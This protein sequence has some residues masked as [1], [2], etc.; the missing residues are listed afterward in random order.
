LVVWNYNFEVTAKVRLPEPL[1]T[2]GILSGQRDIIVGTSTELMKIPGIIFS[3]EVDQVNEVWDNFDMKPEAGVRPPG[4]LRDYLLTK[5]MKGRTMLLRFDKAAKIRQFIQTQNLERSYL[6]LDAV[7]NL[8]QLGGAPELDEKKARGIEEM[9]KLMEQPRP[10]E[11]KAANA[12]PIEPSQG[13]DHNPPGATESN[14][15]KRGLGLPRRGNETN[16]ETGKAVRQF[17]NQLQQ[18]ILRLRGDCRCRY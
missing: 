8:D 4:Q 3:G 7:Q 1:F 16:R 14:Q 9:R 17:G 11:A 2:C 5:K 15:T 12:E 10:V 6:D 18:R 13:D